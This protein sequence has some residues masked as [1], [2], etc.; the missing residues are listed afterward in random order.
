MIE[1]QK[2]LISLFLEQEL[3]KQKIIIDVENNSQEISIINHRISSEISNTQKSF[4]KDFNK[5]IN[6]SLGE[7][8][9]PAVRYNLSK[10]SF[11]SNDSFSLSIEFFNE[12]IQEEKNELLKLHKRHKRNKKI[13]RDIKKDTEKNLEINIEIEN[14]KMKIAEIQELIKKSPKAKTIDKEKLDSE[15]NH[16]NEELKIFNDKKT[17]LEMQLKKYES[18]VSEI[19]KDAEK[20]MNNFEESNE[21]FIVNSFMELTNYIN[22]AKESIQNKLKGITLL[23]EKKTLIVRDNEALTERVKNNG[24]DIH[25]DEVVEQFSSSILY[26]KQFGR[27]LKIDDKLYFLI[28]HHRLPLSMQVRPFTMFIDD[29]LQKKPVERVIYNE[30]SMALEH[31]MKTID[32]SNKKDYLSIFNDYVNNERDVVLLKSGSELNENT[33][34]YLES[35]HFINFCN[36][37]K[38][39]NV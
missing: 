27:V 39:L 18:E 9:F 19:K 13:I 23:R 28:D 38:I 30:R 5:Y 33:H 11:D 2:E 3:K 36:V 17:A 22:Q 4:E 35:K 25:F 34:M 12:K 21:S 31:R 16:K 14:L 1:L 32:W 26:H 6:S 37:I 7:F 8:K 29:V 24:G 20:Y 10:L 15:I